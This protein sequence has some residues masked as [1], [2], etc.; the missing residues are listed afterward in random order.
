MNKVKELLQWLA[1]R[2]LMH[3]CL[4]TM[5]SLI[6]VYLVVMLFINAPLFMLL[7]SA[8]FGGVYYIAAFVIPFWAKLLGDNDESI[9]E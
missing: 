4:I 8:I 7:I 6:A 2:D 9:G 5:I 3:R 1:G